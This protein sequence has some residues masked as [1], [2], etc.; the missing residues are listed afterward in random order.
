[1]LTLRFSH[2]TRVL[3]SNF[4]AELETHGY[5]TIRHI[6]LQKRID[7]GQVK[8]GQGQIDCLFYLTLN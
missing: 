7:Q 4:D 5:Y 3:W 8:K 6:F 2:V 1:M